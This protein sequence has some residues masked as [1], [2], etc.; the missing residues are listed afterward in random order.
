M[1]V[2]S[3]IIEP[4]LFEIYSSKKQ[5]QALPAAY[6]M[7]ASSLAY[8]SSLKMEAICPSETSVDFHHITALCIPEDGTL[9]NKKYHTFAT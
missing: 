9:Q 1:S 7:L 5:N 3:Y 8:S 2:L 4:P 6:F